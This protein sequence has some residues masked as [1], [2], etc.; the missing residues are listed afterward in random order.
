MVATPLAASQAAVRAYDTDRRA[1]TTELRFGPFAVNTDASTLS[2]D[3]VELR[4]RPRVFHALR[5]LASRPGAFV[6][7]EGLM[8]DAWEGTHVSRHTIDVTLAELRRHLG[9]YGRWVVHRQ[10]R[11][12]ALVVP[13]ADDLVRRGWHFW[14]QHTRAGY[15]RAIEYFTRATGDSPSDFRAFEG[16]SVSYLTVAVAG[17]R[18]PIDTYPRFL[19]AHDQAVR[20]SGPRP[21]LCCNRAFGLF[22]IEQRPAESEVQLLRLLDAV[23]SLAT[24]CVRLGLLYGSRGRFDEALAM[25]GRS[26]RLDPLQPT[27]AS[28]E[29][30]VHCWRR[31]FAAAAALGREAVALHPHQP[32]LRATYAQALERSGHPDEALAQHR[33]AVVIAPDVPWLQAL[34]G[35]CLAALGRPSRARQTLAR[36]DA[37]RRSEYVD[38]YFMAVLQSALGRPRE[39]LE[40]LQRALAEQSSQLYALEVDPQLDALRA[41]PGFRRLRRRSRVS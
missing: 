35:A 30:L 22:A 20:L 28:T 19:A 29:L 24:A 32:V 23:P 9:E 5:V 18:C 7:Y 33:I 40:E 8:A 41:E 14:S 1:V 37:R 16:L 4:L 3:G 10:Q 25:L 31:D 12:Y 27:L 2:R 26:R 38:A 34:E 15:D 36:L 13:G 21:E 6:G 39:A 11:G 17:L